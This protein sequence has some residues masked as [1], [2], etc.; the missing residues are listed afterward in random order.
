MAKYTNCLYSLNWTVLPKLPKPG[1]ESRILHQVL[2][3]E[4]HTVSVHLGQIESQ[5]LF[6]VKEVEVMIAD[7]ALYWVQ[8]VLKLP[9]NMIWSFINQ[10]PKVKN[11]E[12]TPSAA[13]SIEDHGVV[14]TI[15]VQNRLLRS[16]C[17]QIHVL[18]TFYHED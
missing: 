10:K 2:K 16:N 15:R 6:H 12:P 17:S 3:I 14:G 4:Q 8:I 9:E 18:D 7:V 11:L 13:L 1:C 5:V